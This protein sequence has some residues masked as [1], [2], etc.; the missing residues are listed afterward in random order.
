MASLVFSGSYGFI[1][2]KEDVS[3]LVLADDLRD[4]LDATDLKNLRSIRIVPFIGNESFLGKAEPHFSKY[5]SYC[6][7]LL[8]E[9]LFPDYPEN[10]E[11]L[12]N[13]LF[14]EMWHCVENEI[15]Y[16]K[17]GDDLYAETSMYE[18]ALVHI[19]HEIFGEYFAYRK[20]GYSFTVSDTEKLINAC[21]GLEKKA[22]IV[23]ETIRAKL[24]YDE[25][26]IFDALS[27]AFYLIARISA[28]CDAKSIS[29][30]ETFASTLMGIGA[31]NNLYLIR[32][33]CELLD[34]TYDSYLERICK[35]RYCEIGQTAIKALSVGNLF[36]ARM[37]DG[38]FDFRS[39]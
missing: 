33:V 20:V 1:T 11:H 13:V 25:K 26:I 28:S 24:D 3:P 12:R 14:H 19:G 36:F 38:T 2:K 7:I 34:N 15:S 39:I 18:T 9:T 23:A 8:N 21:N 32:M 17:I 31:E 29:P 22:K 27:H 4:G 30:Y 35:N 6:D 37:K 5:E 10:R 16:A